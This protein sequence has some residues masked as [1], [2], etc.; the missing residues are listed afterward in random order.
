MPRKRSPKAFCRIVN[1]VN[2]PA[3]LRLMTAAAFIIQG[4]NRDIAGTRTVSEEFSLGCCQNTAVVLGN[5]VFNIADMR[6]VVEND[7]LFTV[8]NVQIVGHDVLAE[9][10][11]AY[12]SPI[13]S[14]PFWSRSAIRYWV[15]NCRKIPAIR[16]DL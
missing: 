8:M 5:H 10:E 9:N 13:V 14:L 7:T 12:I 16:L 11:A 4:T 15:W 1:A 3:D 2:E 6:G